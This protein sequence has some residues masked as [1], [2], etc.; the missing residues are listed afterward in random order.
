MN[1][2]AE[3]QAQ[4]SKRLLSVEEAAGYLGISART[5]YNGV[6][7]KT[8]KPFPVKPKRWGKRILFDILDLK[9]HV[10]GMPTG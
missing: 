2:M 1:E 9:A 8:K 6:A 4:V 7:P 3:K 5:I 10:D